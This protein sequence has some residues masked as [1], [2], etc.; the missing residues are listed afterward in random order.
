MSPW[1][2]AAGR[3]GVGN[4]TAVSLIVVVFEGQ[5]NQSGCR[6]SYSWEEPEI[7][8]PVSIS[9]NENLVIQ[10]SLVEFAL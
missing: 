9:F 10:Q 5:L 1:E 3:S 8:S 2:I 4:R 6:W 7:R